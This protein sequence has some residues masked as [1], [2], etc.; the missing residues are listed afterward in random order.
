MT[1]FDEVE[2]YFLHLTGHQAAETTGTIILILSFSFMISR[3]MAFER[4]PQALPK[5]SSQLSPARL[6]RFH[7]VLIVAG[8]LMDDVSITLVIAPLFL[9]LMMANG[10]DGVHFAANVGCSVVI[11]INSPP[12]APTLFRSCKITRTP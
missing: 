11:L 3:I 9:P 2:G 6:A 7:L 4:V 12:V 1:G 10:V 5:Q 8:A